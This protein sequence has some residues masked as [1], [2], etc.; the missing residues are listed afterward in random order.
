MVAL[1][2]FLL[3]AS[4]AESTE[5]RV[6]RLQETLVAPCCWAETVAVH[7]SETAA[8]I[9]AEVGALVASGKSDREILDRFKSQY[10]A[11]IL[12]EPEGGL[13][14]WAYFIPTAAAMAGLGLVVLVLRRFLSTPSSSPASTL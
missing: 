13:R 9:R 6:R 5:A 12:V 10:G 1:V 7:R 3:A 2:L 8:Q 14:L 11:R 4:P